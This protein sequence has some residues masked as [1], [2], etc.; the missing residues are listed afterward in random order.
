VASSLARYLWTV[1]SFL[2]EVF[3]SVVA[4]QMY[5]RA[6]TRANKSQ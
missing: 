6:L 1:L 5:N 4:L 2:R 3:I